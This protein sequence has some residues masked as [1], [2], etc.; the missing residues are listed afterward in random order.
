MSSCCSV[1]RKPLNFLT[2]NGV[3]DYG[4]LV[5]RAEHAEEIEKHEAAKAAVAG[6]WK[7]RT[8]ILMW[9]CLTP[10]VSGSWTSIPSA[11]SRQGRLRTICPAWRNRCKIV[12]PGW[13]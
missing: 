6:N 8:Q 7:M 13:L 11:R 9:Q 4:E 2:E 5:E 12:C 1:G 10:K 3:E